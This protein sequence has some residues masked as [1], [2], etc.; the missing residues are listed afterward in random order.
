MQSTVAMTAIGGGAGEV[1]NI[2]D[3]SHIQDEVVPVPSPEI[4]D[5]SD[6]LPTAGE[7]PLR[8]LPIET[9][10]IH[11]TAT[12]GASWGTIADFHVRANGWAAIGYTWGTSVDGKMFRL[13]DPDR[14]GNQTG[15]HNSR[16]MGLVMDGNYHTGPLGDAQKQATERLALH[17]A[18]QYGIP[19]IQPH[20][21]LKATACPGRYAMDALVGL[22]R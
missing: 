1:V 3:L 11:H 14:V 20:R 16:T 18:D 7:Y 6:D 21:N 4:V 19:H 10:V 8:R 22:W 2:I 13:L 12:T 5:L 15:G 17:V 9:L